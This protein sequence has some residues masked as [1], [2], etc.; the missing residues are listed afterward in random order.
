MKI[1][2]LSFDATNEEIREE[3]FKAFHDVYDSKW[4]ILGNNVKK[5][6]Q[7]YAAFNHTNYCVG[8]SN[9]LD[10]LYLCLKA[11]GIG[12]GDEVIVPSNTYI[13][14]LLAVSYVGAKPVLVEP[15][16]STY[17]LNPDLLEEAITSKTKAIMPVHLYGQC[18]EMDEI[19]KIANK[20]GLFV[21][22]DNAQAHGAL[23]N[24]KL[25][26]SFG[27]I[28]ATSFYPGKSLGALGEAGA[29]TTNRLDLAEKVKSFRNYGSDKK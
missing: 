9:G 1:P 11:L 18:C 3:M 23:Y 29:I 13:A 21:I 8:V 7:E 25:T 14:T 6:E 2:F 28:N 16:K 26:G 10:A 4:Y 5:F 17:N 20:H 22:E 15:R 19:T 27:H 24:G 12:D